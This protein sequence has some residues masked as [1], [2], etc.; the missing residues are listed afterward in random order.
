MKS[1]T[2]AQEQQASGQMTQANYNQ[3]TWQLNLNL[4]TV[5]SQPESNQD[6]AVQNSAARLWIALGDLKQAKICADKAGAL[7]PGDPKPILTS[8][9]IAYQMRDYG[10]A[11]KAAAQA[12]RLNPEDK[13]AYALWQLSRS[14]GAAQPAAEE[15]A[16][17]SARGLG[18][19]TEL[20]AM[21]SPLE[22]PELAVWGRRSLDRQAAIKALNEAAGRFKL[23]AHADALEQTRLAVERDPSLPDAY[24]Q[25]ALILMSMK[26][27]ARAESE[28]A[29]AI[30]LWNLGEAA[31][32]RPLA[33]AYATRAALR[34]E[35]K[36]FQS[37]VHDA[38]AAL[39]ANPKSAAAFY[40]RGAARAGLGAAPAEALADY[41]EAAAL[42]PQDY[43]AI[44]EA[45]LARYN[46]A[47][48]SG[49][50]ACPVSGRNGA[51]GAS[52]LLVFALGVFTAS[53][54]RRK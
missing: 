39:Q 48:G 31:D 43:S 40:Y 42:A 35:R 13:A 12:L 53:R 46:K 49:R 28:L 29:K 45:A 4:G 38:E 16:Q 18:A 22:H 52:A 5:L 27:P 15:G 41:K 23:G 11:A 47:G 26:E 6:P 10:G 7:A 20:L 44:Y 54:L 24:M 51:M 30:L 21:S 37:A 3:F 33:A 25:R 8:G 36:D 32:K 17:V 19:G 14:R 1:F 2:K 9:I 50:G 34:L